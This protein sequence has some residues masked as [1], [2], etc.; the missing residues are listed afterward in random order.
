MFKTA[1]D[2]TSLRGKLTTVAIAAFLV[3]VTEG[4]GAELVSNKAFGRDSNV[5]S[6]VLKKA[7]A[8]M[9]KM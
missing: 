5:T 7:K 8:S 4:G 1:F 9:R 6:I 3:G 2:G